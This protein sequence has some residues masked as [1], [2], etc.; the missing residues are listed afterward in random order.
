MSLAL[1]GVQEDEMIKLRR[2]AAIRQKEEE[3][4]R[5][6]L[7]EEERKRKELDDVKRE[8][9]AF[10]ARRRAEKISLLQKQAKLRAI[11]QA[12]LEKLEQRREK[13]IAE[14]DAAW[15]KKENLDIK[16]IKADAAEKERIVQETWNDARA[17]KHAKAH[18][19]R[20]RKI[21]EAMQQDELDEQR[22]KAIAD[23]A[24]KRKIRDAIRVDAIKE[25]AEAELLSFIQNP[26][27]VPLK[28]V[29]CGRLRPVPTVTELLA[30]KKDA[31][32]EFDELKEQD[33]EL[34]A[35]IRNQSLFQYVH[36]IQARA[37]ELRIRPPEPVAGDLVKK[38]MR[39]PR[40][41]KSG[42]KSGGKVVSPSNTATARKG[43]AKRFAGNN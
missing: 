14:R 31:Q 3:F 38:A 8:H 25:E 18:A 2:D 35:V 32:E 33:F 26:Y 40:S 39:S 34:R 19:E 24:E 20:E 6:R 41:P 29:L 9:E 1:E 7:E 13:K 15:L 23:L 4:R 17:K 5:R 30:A 16:R 36:D 10:E 27:P 21:E 12:E 37:E 11:K 43:F 42:G 22:D 28:Q